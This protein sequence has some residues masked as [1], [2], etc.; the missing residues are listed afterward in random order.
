LS[1]ERS[2]DIMQP[3]SMDLRARVVATIEAH[4][5]SFRQIAR[6]FR[7]SLSFVT[8][9]LKRRRETGS[10]FPKGHG[11][12]HPAAVEGDDLERLRQLVEQHPDATLEELAALLGIP[13][14]RT[15]IGRALHKL[16]I[17]R[18]KKVLHAEERDR[19]DVQRQREAFQEQV[20]A[21]AP[22]RLHFVDESGATTAMTRTYGRAPCGE[23]VQGAVPGSWQSVSLICGL[24]LSGVGPA[25]AF[26]GATDNQAM[27]TYVD[28]MLVPELKPG[29]IVIWDNLKIH[30]NPELVRSI[31]AAGAVVLPL[32]PYSPDLTPIE[33]LFSKAKEILRSMAA[34]TT[35]AVYTAMGQA[36]TAVC[37]Q[38]IIGWFQSCGLCA[39]QT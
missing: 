36:L 9:L 3:Y 39:S 27:Q 37:P 18:K 17:T 8:R 30:K 10:F 26:P 4:E 28:K 22:E 13:C 7:V 38:D 25:L 35:E 20:Q 19:P 34:R 1:P 21:L 31:Q 12:G 5:G 33:K 14:S 23:R 2:G 11:G 29:D 15:A 24:S 32:P 16:R 6:R